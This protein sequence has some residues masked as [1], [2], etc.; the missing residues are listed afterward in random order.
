MDG[1]RIMLR[2]NRLERIAALAALV[3]I[4]GLA[5]PWYRAPFERQLSESG[6]E[7]FGFAQA[8]LLLTAAAALFLVLRSVEGHKPPLPLHEGTLL[9]IAG[10]WSAAIVVFLMV[11]RP[12]IQVGVFDTDYGLALGIFVELGAAVALV[13]AGWTLRSRELRAESLEARSPSASSPA[14]SQR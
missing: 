9:A 5:L 7:S 14:R 13:A 1:W 12:R 4:G 8:A 6:L 2:S 10:L 3:C 11:D